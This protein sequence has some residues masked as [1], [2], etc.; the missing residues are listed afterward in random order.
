MTQPTPATAHNQ[1]PNQP[2]PDRLVWFDGDLVP[3]DRAKVSVFDHGLLYGDGVFEGIRAYNGKV[4]KLVTH[5]QR[6]FAS[7]RR[8]ELTIPYTV[9]QLADATR[10]TLEANGLADAY[11][12]LCVTRGVGKLGINPFLCDNPTTFIIT[13]LV[14]L[15]PQEMYDHGLKI[16]T[17]KTV[18]NHPNALDPRIKSMNYLNNILAKIEGIKAGCIETL[19]LNHEGKVAE[20]TGDNIFIVSD[21]ELLTP[22]LHAGVLEGITRNLVLGLARD[23]GV[24][25]READMVLDDV[26][27]AD[28]CFLTGTAAE[29]IPVI[30]I[31]Q[32]TVGT[33]KPGPLTQQLLEAF[34]RLVADAPED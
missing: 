2:T 11:I 29:V 28:E 12:R 20:C 9:D 25:V 21:G 15:Y 1:A 8:I 13:D 32:K 14:R 7:A 17:A 4:L 33:G 6:L 34:H 10:A 27:N 22:P 19:M 24:T 5:L 26:Y 31:D 16:V 3:A 23:A 18:R 30:G